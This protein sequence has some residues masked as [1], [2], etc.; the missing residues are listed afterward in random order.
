M[1]HA[2]EGLFDRA[3]VTTWNRGGTAEVI[4]SSGANHRG[5]EPHK[6]GCEQNIIVFDSGGYAYRLCKVPAGGISKVTEQCFRD[7][8]LSF[9]GEHTWIWQKTKTK[10]N[11]LT[12][13]N[14][15]WKQQRAVRT[16]QGTTPRGS[17]WAKIDLPAPPTSSNGV[18]GLWTFLDYVEVPASLEPGR[19]VLSFRWDAQGTPQVWN[20]CANIN[21]V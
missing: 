19:Y 15:D 10:G 7:G 13:N 21:I 6:A 17:Q 2:A 5:M 3:P 18:K 12:I 8:H 4:W 9:S 20:S 1:E 11:P 14:A 16:R